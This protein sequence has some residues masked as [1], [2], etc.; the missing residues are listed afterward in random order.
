M[1]ASD[2]KIMPLKQIQDDFYHDSSKNEYLQH[3][4]WLIYDHTTYRKNFILICDLGGVP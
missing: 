3:T 2:E 4:S 1:T